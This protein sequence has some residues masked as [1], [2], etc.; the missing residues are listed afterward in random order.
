[1]TPET[2][3]GSVRRTELSLLSPTAG[4]DAR[5][6][7]DAADRLLAL[8][9]RVRQ[10]LRFLDYPTMEWIP[11][12]SAPDGE[13]VYDVVI[14]GAGQGGLS[15]GFGLWREKVKN[16]LLLDRSDPGREGPWVTY[17]RMLTYRSPKHVTGTDMGV[18]SLTPQAYYVTVYG[19]QAWRELGKW[20]RGVWMDYLVWYRKM[21][22][23][24]VRNRT[25]VVSFDPDGAF[26]RVVTRATDSGAEGSVLARKLVLATGIEGNGDWRPANLDLD[27]LPPDRYSHTNAEFD[28]A[29]LRGKRVGV[30]GAGASAFDTAAAALE[31]GAASVQQ[32]VRREAIAVINPFRWMEKAGF[33]RHFGSMDDAAR[34]DWMDAVYRN[35]MPPTQDGIKRCASF[36]NYSIAYGTNWAR[37]AMRDE[38]VE[39]TLIDGRRRHFDFLI[40]GTGHLVDIGLRPELR[41]HAGEIALWKDR[42]RLSDQ[43]QD[44][45]VGLFPYLADDLSFQE[46]RPGMAPFLKNVHYFTFVATASVGFSGAS[47]TGLK[48]GVERL[49]YGLTRFFWLE[50][51][52]TALAE[53]RR[54]ADVDLDLS[55]IEPHRETQHDRA[56]D[57]GRDRP[58]GRGRSTDA[59][60]Q[61]GSVAV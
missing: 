50:E 4:L 18:P 20:P 22:D 7:P 52:G 3:T 59:P 36:S 48:Y 32:F 11:A 8:E 41:L 23:L 2:G 39:V 34:W 51:A 19:E 47:L 55:P 25:E 42:Y 38:D 27:A 45:Q 40:L 46:K 26:L 56:A 12:R 24:P 1:M 29:A 5:P 31:G 6:L 17:A 30:L 13:H 37:V 58:I 9:E 53:I 33:L 43:Q 60:P 28:V 57:R 35:G 61:V 49:V 44:S 14:V 15:I 16:I 54:Y 21:V 10:D